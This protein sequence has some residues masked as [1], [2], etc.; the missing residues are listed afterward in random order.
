[1]RNIKKNRLEIDAVSRVASV[2]KKQ[3]KKMRRWSID[4]HSSK[5]FEAARIIIKHLKQKVEIRKAKES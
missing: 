2:E 1:M 5:H 3:I 4:E